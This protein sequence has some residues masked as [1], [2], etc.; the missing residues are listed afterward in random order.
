MVFMVFLLVFVAR[1]E[2]DRFQYDHCRFVNAPC[3]RISLTI[4]QGMAFGHG[5]RSEEFHIA[6]MSLLILSPENDKAD[7]KIAGEYAPGINLLPI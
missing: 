5:G 2:A 1:R 4:G 7:S 6:T 3:G